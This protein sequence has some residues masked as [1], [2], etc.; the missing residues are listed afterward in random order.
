AHELVVDPHRVV[1]VLVL[2][3]HDVLATEV[4]VVTGVAQRADLVLF[5]RLGLDELFDVGVVDVEDD[6][7][8]RTPRR[9]TGLDRAGGGVRT[10]HEAD[11]AAGGAAG[12][13][14]LLARANPRQVETGT[15]A[16]LDDQALFPVPV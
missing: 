1:R 16:A 6:L 10:A 13:Q 3:G 4:H 7:L 2:H 9:A 11:R 15:R 8:R 14:Q 5:T 12:G